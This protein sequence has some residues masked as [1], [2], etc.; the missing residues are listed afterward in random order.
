MD[1]N[2]A[3][4]YIHGTYKFGSKLGLKNIK[5]LLKRLGNPEKEFKY[6]HIA[7]TNGK[8]SVTSM[9][10]HI[11]YEAGY[12]VGMFVSPY[13]E[14]FTERIQVNLQEMPREDLAKIAQRVKGKIDEMVADGSNHPTEFE[15]VTAIGLVFFAEK[16]VD[17]AVVEV[18]LGGR[19]DSTNIVEEPLVSV[20]TTIDFDHMHILGD[21]LDKIAYEKAGIIK[22]GRPVISYPQQDDAARVIKNIAKDRNAPLYLVTK[23]QISVKKTS[24]HENIFDFLYKNSKYKGLRLKLVGEHQ[25]LNAATALTTIEVIKELGVY[26]SKEAIISGL[27][28]TRWPGRLEKVYENPTIIIDGAHNRSGARAL[29]NTMENYFSQKGITLVLGI[30]KDKEVE[31]IISNIC[32]LAHTTIITKPDNPRAME[33]EEL[34]ERVKEYCDNTIIEN[35][36]IKAIDKAKDISK[37]QGT[38]LVCG[39]LYLA[40][41]ARH[42]I[43]SF[44]D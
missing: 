38:V 14:N 30:L 29:A 39:S 9:L 13:L 3:L 42:H 10:S 17:I 37:N 41:A 19:L 8:G 36:L 31:G 6:I 11:L 44:Y 34:E 25:T 40:G 20:I 1:Y 26:I 23:D 16:K 27:C 18:G 4:D 35:N 33:P 2:Q 7:G 12:R 28:K 21:T 24:I 15:I 43:K 5:E 32:P 22:T